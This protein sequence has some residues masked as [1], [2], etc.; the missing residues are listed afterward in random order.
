MD[1]DLHSLSIRGFWRG[2]GPI[3]STLGKSL[4]SSY[5]N[6]FSSGFVLREQIL[7]KKVMT[8]F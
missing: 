2:P 6:G 7:R 1:L 8:K 3:G 4:F 5:T